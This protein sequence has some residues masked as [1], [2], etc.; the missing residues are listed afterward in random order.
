MPI[1]WDDKVTIDPKPGIDPENKVTDADMNEIK[2]V[3]NTNETAI[4]TKAAKGGN[5]NP[6]FS[7]ETVITFATNIDLDLSTRD[8]FEIT[9]TGNT[10]ITASNLSK[11]QVITITFIIDA[12]GGYTITLDPAVFKAFD[13]AA[14]LDNTALKRNLV[15]G[16][17]GSTEIEYLTQKR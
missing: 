10:S 13:D 7:N 4:G 1:T 14:S 5:T 6:L 11:G 15:V 3:V 9:V 2:D 17:V 16:K 8:N 12:I